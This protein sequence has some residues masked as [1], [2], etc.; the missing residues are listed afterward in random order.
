ML[1]EVSSSSSNYAQALVCL[2]LKLNASPISMAQVVSNIESQS[3]ASGTN[4]GGCSRLKLISGK[5]GK[6]SRGEMNA[7]IKGN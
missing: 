2:K 3:L 1:R 5:D 6:Q 7:D 4:Q